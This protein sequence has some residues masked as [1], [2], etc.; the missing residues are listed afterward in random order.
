MDSIHLSTPPKSANLVAG[1]SWAA[2]LGVRVG[3]MRFE[4]AVEAVVGFD[5]SLRD[6]RLVV[7]VE[8]ESGWRVEVEGSGESGVGVGDGAGE[9][10]EKFLREIPDN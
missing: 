1:G 3:L 6:F 10:R 9:L 2:G 8:G 4:E 7:L 5:D